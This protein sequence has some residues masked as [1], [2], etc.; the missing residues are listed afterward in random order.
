ME[1]KA[2]WEVHRNRFCAIEK[3]TFFPWSRILHNMACGP[4]YRRSMWAT[5]PSHSH[6]QELPCGQSYDTGP[7]G[8]DCHFPGWSRWTINC[9][10]ILV[11]TFAYD[12]YLITW[13][14]GILED[15]ESVSMVNRFNFMYGKF[16]LQFVSFCPTVLVCASSWF[17]VRITVE[18]DQILHIGNEI[19]VKMYIPL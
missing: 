17:T 3:H 2:L 14:I 9:Q 16:K 12:S 10:S 7:S 18:I 6:K 4:G 15:L 5:L 19:V 8:Q 1:C 13:F 11:Y